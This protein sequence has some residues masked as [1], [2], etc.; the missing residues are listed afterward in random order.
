MELGSQTLGKALDKRYGNLVDWKCLLVGLARLGG[1][2]L[3]PKFKS[4]SEIAKAN[5]AKLE[6]FVETSEASLALLQKR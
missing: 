1:G 6:V 5:V 4:Q 3:L 2:L